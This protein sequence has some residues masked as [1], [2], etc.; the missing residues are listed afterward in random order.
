MW[1]FWYSIL[2]GARRSVCERRRIYDWAAAGLV[3]WASA[4][5]GMTFI[6]QTPDPEDEKCMSQALPRQFRSSFM[7]VSLVPCLDL[8]GRASGRW[9]MMPHS[10]AARLLSASP[11]L[12]PQQDGGSQPLLWKAPVNYKPWPG[13]SSPSRGTFPSQSLRHFFP[14]Y[15]TAASFSSWVLLRLRHCAYKDIQLGVTWKDKHH[16][17]YFIGKFWWCCGRFYGV[18]GKKKNNFNSWNQKRVLNWSP[19]TGFSEIM[20]TQKMGREQLWLVSSH[21]TGE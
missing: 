10:P 19:R 12:H 11:A 2:C 21:S 18:K 5:R 8:T 20:R 7:P 16:E 17:C 4:W 3:I 13:V 1:E 6:F 9:C 15:F 14:A